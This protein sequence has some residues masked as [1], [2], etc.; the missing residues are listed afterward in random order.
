MVASVGTLVVDGVAL[1]VGTPGASP[2]TD[3]LRAALVDIQTG[4]ATFAW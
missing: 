1:P 4:R 2:R 3:Q